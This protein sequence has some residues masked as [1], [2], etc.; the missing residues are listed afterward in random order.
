MIGPERAYFSAS[1]NG[2]KSHRDHDTTQFHDLLSMIDPSN[3]FLRG[4]ISLFFRRVLNHIRYIDIRTVGPIKTD[5]VAKHACVTST[6]GSAVC[7]R[8]R[9]IAY[10]ANMI[11]IIGVNRHATTTIYRVG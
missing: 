10:V 4:V 5:C 2:W 9:R 11:A 7:P 8:P 3:K 1:V 6:V